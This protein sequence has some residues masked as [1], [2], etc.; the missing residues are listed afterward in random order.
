MEAPDGSFAAFALV[1]VDAANRTAIFE[2]VG[3]HPDHRRRGL[4]R[5]LLVECCARLRTRGLVQALVGTST[6]N[7]AATSLYRS[8]GFEP[9]DR[10]RE[11]RLAL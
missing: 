7:E 11:W 1:W 4:T 8:A 10:L 9:Q 6:T 5:A 2:P 3:C